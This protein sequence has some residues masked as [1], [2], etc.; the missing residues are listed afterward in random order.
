MFAKPF[1]FFSPAKT[2]DPTLEG[3][4][5]VNHWYDFTD[6]VSMSFS[7]DL[8]DEIYDKG[9]F[10]FDAT[11]SGPNVSASLSKPKFIG[12]KKGARFGYDDTISVIGSGTSIPT[13]LGY[14][15]NNTGYSYTLTYVGVYSIED[16]GGS[17]YPEFPA[18]QLNEVTS[19]KNYWPLGGVPNGISGSGVF[20]QAGLI[21]QVNGNYTGINSIPPLSSF[22]MYAFRVDYGPYGASKN[23]VRY[24][25]YNG[26]NFTNQG[27]VSYGEATRGGTVLNL[28][29][30]SDA[31]FTENHYRGHIKH[32][33]CFNGALTNQ[34]FSDLWSHYTDTR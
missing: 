19:G 33:M 9:T 12:R 18:L 14:G 24:T 26:N 16:I 28:S 22:N 23:G 6:P 5:Q 11:L 30:G 32:I 25:A 3:T 2:F 10:G 31:Y 17:E 8:V 21:T 13:T 4:L 1:G 27:S 7:G 20:T 15:T 34:N 29:I